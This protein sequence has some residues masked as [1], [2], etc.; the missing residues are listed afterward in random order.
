M[1]S[2]IALGRRGIAKSVLL[3]SNSHPASSNPIQCAS[4]M[5]FLC[6][7]WHSNSIHTK[8][9]AGNLPPCFSVALELFVD[10]CISAFC[11]DSSARR[12]HRLAVHTYLLSSMPSTH[13]CFKFC[14]I[15]SRRCILDD[16]L[17]HCRREH[18]KWISTWNFQAAIQSAISTFSLNKFTQFMHG[19]ENRNHCYSNCFGLNVLA[20]RHLK[21]MVHRRAVV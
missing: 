14:L 4:L 17:L 18:M 11:Q 12:V 16:Y 2:Q 1:P 7:W 5:A 9:N 19:A 15:H 6:I 8:K 10:S 3:V 13:G 21:A 20:V